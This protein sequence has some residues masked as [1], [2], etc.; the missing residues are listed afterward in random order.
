MSFP[1]VSAGPTVIHTAV[2]GLAACFTHVVQQPLNIGRRNCYLIVGRRTL[3][4]RLIG[5]KSVAA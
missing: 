3:L 5:V 1:V 4:C 2:D